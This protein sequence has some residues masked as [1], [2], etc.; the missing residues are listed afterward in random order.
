MFLC[1]LFFEEKSFT[2]EF[3]CLADCS[4]NFGAVIAG[5]NGSKEFAKST[6]TKFLTHHGLEKPTYPLWS[7]TGPQP[8]DKWQIVSTTA[9]L[10]IWQFFNY[11]ETSNLLF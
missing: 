1:L 3:F 2:T 11:T 9:G 10:F 6:A 5:L 7:A 8:S 4:Y